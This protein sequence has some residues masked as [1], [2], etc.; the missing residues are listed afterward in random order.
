MR[1]RR[2]RRRNERRG[3]VKPEYDAAPASGDVLT[4]W[5]LQH[6]D[7]VD[8]IISHS[9]FESVTVKVCATQR[10]IERYAGRKDTKGEWLISETQLKAGQ[11]F[12]RDFEAAGLEPHVTCDMTREVRGGGNGNSISGIRSDARNRYKAALKAIPLGIQNHA[13]NVIC[14]DKGATEATLFETAQQAIDNGMRD[15]RLALDMLAKHYGL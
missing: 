5:R 4:K 1:K 9:A 13:Q 3:R 7:F 15:L 11:R 10:K 14:F 12:Y 2:A 8:L 6:D